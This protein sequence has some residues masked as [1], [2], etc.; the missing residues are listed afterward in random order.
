MKNLNVRVVL[1]ILFIGLVMFSCGKDEEP[2]VS[3]DELRASFQYQISD[4]DFAEVTF[5]NFSQNATS[6]SWDFGDNNSSTE[7]NPVHR[8]DSEGEFRVVLTASNGTDQ[9]SFTEVISIEDP[10]SIADGLHGGTSKVWKLSRDVADEIFPVLVGPTDRSEVWW[11]LGRED[12][13]G[14]RPCMMEE[15]YIFNADGS[16]VYNTNGEIFADFGIWNV[17]V[18]GMC[19]S[20]TDASLMTGP[21]GEDLLAWGGG[22]FTYEFDPS[23]ST[24]VLNGKGAHVGLA[25]VGTDAEYSTP[26]DFVRYSVV[27]LETDGP[28][29]RMILETTLPNGYWQINL[30]SYDNPNDEPDLGLVTPT[31]GFNFEVEDRTVNFVNNS[32]S[33]DSY[34]WDFGDGNTSTEESPSHVYATDGLFVVRLTAT[35]GNGNSESAQSVVVS[36]TSTFSADVLSTG[37]KTWKLSPTPGVLR[38]GSA[39]GSGEWFSMSEQNVA[40]R[41][42]AFDDT[43]AF[44]NSGGFTYSTNGDL[45]GEIYMGIDPEICIEESELPSPAAA[46]GSG[47]HTFTITEANGNDPAFITVT[48]TGAFIG[49]PK[50]FNGGEYA[51]GPPAD[52]ASVTYEVM[53]Y[54]TDGS[55]EVIELSIDVSEGQIGGAFWTFVLVSE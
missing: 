1:S 5:S 20:D 31:A 44:D 26:Q 10:N 53:T 43:Y 16:F 12:Q 15:E 9:K 51:S 11:A 14:T 3:S 25:K 7:E 54:A 36:T 41:S 2:P 35:N 39:K 30:V 45:W 8:Y 48:G 47:N 42:C 34:L 40:D 21:N 33:A 23:A 29:D 27:S 24:L 32:T 19:I 37:G 28:I 18:E 49:L 22:T 17:D 6:Y 55:K 52:N 50:A 38:V 13:L 4:T 46:W